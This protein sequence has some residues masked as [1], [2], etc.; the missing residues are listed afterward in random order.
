MKA[1]G[2]SSSA[3]FV[4]N[5]KKIMKKVLKGALSLARKSAERTE[6][7]RKRCEEGRLIRVGIGAGI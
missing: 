4:H 5:V 7:A 3:V 1:H 2:E 6:R